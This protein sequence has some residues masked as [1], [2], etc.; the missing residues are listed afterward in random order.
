MNWLWRGAAVVVVGAHYAFLAYLLVGGF[1]AWRWPRTLVAHLMA[2]TW[3]VLIV[4]MQLDCPLTALQNWLREQRGQ[5]AVPGFIDTYVRSIFYPAGAATYAR[6]AV[7]L[8]VVASWIGLLARRRRRQQRTPDTM[9]PSR[10][11]ELR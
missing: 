1:L 3:A 10:L 2:A 9:L 11:R 4:V 7:A 5:P 6:L 8:I